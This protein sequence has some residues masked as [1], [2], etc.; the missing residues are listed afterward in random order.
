[1][2]IWRSCTDFLPEKR[3]ALSGSRNVRMPRVA[4][5]LRNLRLLHDHG[6]LDLRRRT[7]NWAGPRTA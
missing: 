3:S 2:G 5:T 4:A 7:R 1:M 6:K